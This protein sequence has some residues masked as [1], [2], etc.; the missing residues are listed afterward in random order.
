MPH[1]DASLDAQRDT[2]DDAQLG[3]RGAPVLR[4]AHLVIDVT[5]LER[6]ATFW[7]KL[8]RLPVNNRQPNC[9]DLGPLGA[10]GP[11]LSLQI[12]AEQKVGKNRQ[13]LDFAID[14]ATG[15]VV[16]AGELA[17]S[18]GAMPASGLF[19]AETSPW[20]MW[21]DPDGNEFCLVTEPSVRSAV[22]PSDTGAGRPAV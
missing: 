4:P 21:R 2:R 3:N 13:H 18:L 8:L 10:G 17:R 7:S 22:A 11:V 16:A 19:D 9:V 1:G 20:Q 5:D 15:G 14:P 6:A 12:A